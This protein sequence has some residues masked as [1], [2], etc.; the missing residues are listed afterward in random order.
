V[1]NCF[2]A[3]KEANDVMWRGIAAIAAASALTDAGHN[4]ELISAFKARAY[5]GGPNYIAQI[6]TKGGLMPLDLANVAATTAFAG[7]FRHAGLCWLLTK[8]VNDDN[9]SCGMA[10]SLNVAD[11]PAYGVTDV[12]LVPQSVESQKAAQTWVNKTIEAFA[13]GPQEIR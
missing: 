9:G 8:Y 2:P 10:E 4:V 7:F 11:I 13:A 3:S 1:D 5:G 12:Y 6:V